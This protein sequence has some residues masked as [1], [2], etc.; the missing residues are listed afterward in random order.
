MSERDR[1]L[2]ALHEDLPLF[3][4]A[5]AF[6][7]AHTKFASRLIE[8]DYYCTLLLAY[9]AQEMGRHMV[10]KG[11][12]ALAKILADFYRLS[13]DL[14]FVIP[15]PVDA[16]RRQRSESAAAIKAAVARIDEVLPVFETTE[17]MRGSNQ[18]TQYNGTVRTHSPITGQ[19]ETIRI[20]V[21]LR[22]PLLTPTTDGAARTLLLN[23]ITSQPLVPEVIL[24]CISRVEA[25]AEKF[26]AALTRR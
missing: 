8:K 23:P 5:V 26:R 20:E 14:D 10:F 9:L 3:R 19:P 24:P 11:G 1:P 12:T 2:I 17:S 4:E 22:E 6:T 21:S 13:E 25:L 7:A 18:S 15:L 16:T